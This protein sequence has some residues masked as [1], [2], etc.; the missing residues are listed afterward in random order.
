MLSLESIAFY[1]HSSG[2]TGMPKLISQTHHGAV[3]ILPLLQDLD[4]E[5]LLST[6]TTT[7]LY[8]GGI[9]DIFRSWSAASTL[10]LFP[11]GKL[12]I[13]GPTVSTCI[14][15]IDDIH[16]V[17]N[18]QKLGYL[19]CVPYV[20]EALTE[21]QV[22]LDRLRTLD[23]VG[24]G[25]A[26]M[27]ED[28]GDRLVA[29]G[30]NLISRFGSA[31]CG[32]LLS[33][34]REYR[35]DTGWNQ[36]RYE[37][38][39]G[40]RFTTKNDGLCELGVTEYWPMVSTAIHAKRP[41]DTH[42]LF[43]MHGSKPCT[44]KFVGR[45]DSQ[46]TLKTGKKFDPTAIEGL[47]R[48]HDRILDAFIIGDNKPYIAA[49]L[50]VSN[51]DINPPHDRLVSSLWKYI[52][53]I[54]E[55]QPPH[56]KLSKSSYLVLGPVEY[57][58]VPKNNKGGIIRNAF[59][60]GFA[61]EVSNLYAPSIS[62]ENSQWS[63]ALSYQELKKLVTDFVHSVVDSS[64]VAD[65]EDLFEAGVDSIQAMQIRKQI[66][67]A[68]PANYQPLIL[69]DLVYECGSISK[70]SHF[71]ADL[72]THDGRLSN[73]DKDRQIIQR[74]DMHEMVAKYTTIQPELL[75]QMLMVSGLDITHKETPVLASGRTHQFSDL[76]TV[77]LTG[78]TGFLG[79]HILK[80]I[81]LDKS[82]T[83]VYVLTRGS[84][85]IPPPAYSD[86][87]E[88]A[89]ARMRTLLLQ[90]ALLSTIP[91]G[92]LEKINYLP[93]VLQHPTLGLPNKLLGCVAEEVT[94]MLHCAWEVNFSLS[95]KNFSPQIE[96]TIRLHNLLLL[97]PSKFAK[98]FIF[99]SSIASVANNSKCFGDISRDPRDASDVG[100]AQ[101]KWV[102]ENV[103]TKI[104]EEAFEDC[105][106]IS[107]SILRIGQLSA[108]TKTGIWNRKEAWP[109]M[110]D[111]CLN[112][113][114]SLNEASGGR[115]KEK[116]LIPNLANTSL[117]LI[118]WL[119]VDVAALRV[120]QHPLMPNLQDGPK[121]QVAQI[122]G[123]RLVSW[124]SVQDWVLN[125]AKCQGKYGKI[126]EP[127]DWLDEIEERGLG[128][129]RA[130]I[131]LWRQN[132][133]KE[134]AAKD[135]KLSILSQR[136]TEQLGD[137]KVETHHENGTYELDQRYFE[138]IMDWIIAADL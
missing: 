40:L 68:L 3:G 23:L 115:V 62:Q 116:M 106:R 60:M 85:L 47:L 31:E 125:W 17:D 73:I 110:L 56:A 14:Q 36:L 18:N 33:S 121:I 26:S 10:W 108:N 67:D 59:L 1:F 29:A 76:K 5:V 126:T 74:H 84:S 9:A 77:I 12:P 46:I 13:I 101:S 28:L 55:T 48:K 119:P 69:R 72:P 103:L 112:G 27:L 19:S 94:H 37:S 8:H 90:H 70:I 87:Q 64:H 133:V 53:T 65:G 93:C 95:L 34:Q 81:I 58:R 30:I 124:G 120:L 107:I 98:F 86:Q 88:L 54:N 7:P 102:M 104:S 11:E 78:A 2:T 109:I 111:T 134:G 118:D 79:I 128:K 51:E 6:F 61:N 32:F 80:N 38:T 123:K 129:A 100:Y 122:C 63:T 89:R 96:G 113:F 52:Q 105:S 127:N 71:L 132:W 99:C 42:D 137:M 43:E 131:G 138:R 24:V 20:M 135:I 25:G 49:I 15:K 91:A 117:P 57:K 4:D 35:K 97:K 130:L 16:S 41:F 44:W 75:R 92:D 45:S 82:V 83:K 39:E 66:C 114:K 21:N 50:F 22:L 136:T